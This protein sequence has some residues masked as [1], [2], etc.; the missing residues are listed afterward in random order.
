MRSCHV[1]VGYKANLIPVS[2]G[3][4]E[5]TLD[6]ASTGWDLPISSKRR[7]LLLAVCL[8]LAALAIYER[9]LKHFRFNCERA[10][11]LNPEPFPLTESIFI[12]KVGRNRKMTARRLSDF[13]EGTSTSTLIP[14]PFLMCSHS[15]ITQRRSRSARTQQTSHMINGVRLRLPVPNGAA[16][17]RMGKSCWMTRESSVSCLRANAKILL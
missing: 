11:D 5:G 10:A 9:K 2:W 8:F 3:H 4:C 6:A 17:S 13:A 7:F 14:A 12:L 15:Y 1:S 16:Y